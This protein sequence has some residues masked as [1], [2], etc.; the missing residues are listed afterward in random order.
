[1]ALTQTERTRRYKIKH[2]EKVNANQRAYRT[3]KA[4]KKYAECKRRKL[5]RNRAWFNEYKKTLCCSKCPENHPACLQ[6]HNRDR[7]IKRLNV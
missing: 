6:F 2:R 3:I 1:M 4:P 5:D 7:I